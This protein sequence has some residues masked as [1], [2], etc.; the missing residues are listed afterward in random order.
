MNQHYA[1]FFLLYFFTTPLHVSGSFLA[2]HHDVKCIMWQ[3]YFFNFSSDCLRVWM[4]RICRSFSPQTGRHNR[5]NHDNPAHGSC[6]HTLC[7]APPIPF[8]F[9]V[10]QKDLRRSLMMVGYCRNMWE[11]IHRIK[12]LY[13]SVHIVGFFYNT[14]DNARY[15][16]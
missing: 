15:E 5:R 11:R 16:H 12:K 8:V 1:L 2:H 13:K 4:R 7:D 14:S 6:N 10:T 9:Q 3:L